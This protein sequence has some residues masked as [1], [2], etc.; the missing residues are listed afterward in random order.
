MASSS[1][2][3]RRGVAALA[4]RPASDVAEARLHALRRGGD[5]GPADH[6]VAPEQRQRVVAELALRRRRV[7]LEAVGPA[8]EAARSAGGPRPPDRTAPAG[9]PLVGVPVGAR[10]GSSS[11]GQY[12]STPSTRACAS[13]CLRAQPAPASASAAIAARRSAGGSPAPTASPPAAARICARRGRPARR[14]AL[15]AA[16]RRHAGG[17]VLARRVEADAAFAPRDAQQAAVVHAVEQLGGGVD[18]PPQ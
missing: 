17:G 16:R 7:G 9:A 10:R 3:E 5:V 18:E 2:L 11:A 6:A 14:A 12:Q 8:P 1:G 13:R 4:R 15:R